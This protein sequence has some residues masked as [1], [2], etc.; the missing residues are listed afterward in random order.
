[1]ES[2]I[3]DLGRTGVFGQPQPGGM[4]AL[5]MP[6]FLEADFWLGIPS[7]HISQR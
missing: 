4:F 7:E 2:V 6:N 5:R 3:C 1:M